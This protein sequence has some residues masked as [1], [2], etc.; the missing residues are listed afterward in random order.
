VNRKASDETIMGVS[1]CWVSMELDKYA[2][3]T[4]AREVRYH[5]ACRLPKSQRHTATETHTTEWRYATV[6]H[7]DAETH[8]LTGNR[9][10]YLG[11]E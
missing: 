6:T 9:D 4:T 2:T 11:V 8:T 3:T 10:G 7:A 5:L 1:G